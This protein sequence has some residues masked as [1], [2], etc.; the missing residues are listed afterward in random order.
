MVQ[1]VLPGQDHSQPQGQRENGESSKAWTAAISDQKT[2][3][4]V[5]PGKG[6][7]ELSQPAAKHG[8]QEWLSCL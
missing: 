3:P 2:G 7:E 8:L 5:L 1:L 6:S 4:H